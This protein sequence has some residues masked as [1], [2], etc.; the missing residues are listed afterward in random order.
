M[1]DSDWKVI[2]IVLLV[3]IILLLVTVLII[4]W[5]RFCQK[6]MFELG[7][8][9]RKIIS[10]KIKKCEKGKSNGKGKYSKKSN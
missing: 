8:K 2:L 7:L 9:T 5:I 4:L 10:N 1:S 6:R 3:I